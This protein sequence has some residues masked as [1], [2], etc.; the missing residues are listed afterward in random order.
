MNRLSS[1]MIHYFFFRFIAH[2]FGMMKEIF[3]HCFKNG[4]KK[5]NK[6]ERLQEKKNKQLNQ[7]RKHCDISFPTFFG[8][9]QQKQNGKINQWLGDCKGNKTRAETAYY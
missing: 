6:K 4:Y 8:I 1:E 7:F 2:I 9:S 5:V 3:I